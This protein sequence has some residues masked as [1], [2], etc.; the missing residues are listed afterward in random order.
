MQASNA[1]VQ[2]AEAELQQLQQ[3]LM[4]QQAALGGN[5]ATVQVA[6]LLPH[7]ITCVP[8]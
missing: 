3:H 7:A 6:V 5:R 1:E 8:C 4:T 2:A